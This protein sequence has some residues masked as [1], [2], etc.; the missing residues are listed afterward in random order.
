MHVQKTLDR[1]YKNPQLWCLWVWKHNVIYIYKK[2][3]SMSSRCSTLKVLD[4]Y[5]DFPSPLPL[6]ST[7]T[8]LPKGVWLVSAHRVTK[9]F[10]AF[11]FIQLPL[12][13]CAETLSRLVRRGKLTFSVLIEMHNLPLQKSFSLQTRSSR[14]QDLRFSRNTPVARVWRGPARQVTFSH[15]REGGYRQHLCW[16]NTL[17]CISP[18]WH[19]VDSD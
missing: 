9:S 18:W 15:L 2:R 8:G 5:L 13:K 6:M 4:Q 10:N 12:C 19:L 17:N 3:S 16:P 11:Q 1:H 14:T 7:I